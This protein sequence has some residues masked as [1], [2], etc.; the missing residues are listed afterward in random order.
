MSRCGEHF[1]PWWSS[2]LPRADVDVL[3]AAIR[4]SGLVASFIL[5]CALAL[6]VLADDRL[7]ATTITRGQF[8]D[9]GATTPPPDAAPWEPVTLPDAW[10]TTRPNFQL[11]GWYRLT[12]NV[13]GLPEKE[14]VGLYIHTSRTNTEIY[15]NG[16]YVGASGVIVGPSPDRIA[17]SQLHVLPIPKLR[18]GENVLHLRVYRPGSGGGISDIEVGEYPPLYY[19][20]LTR[21]LYNYASYALVGVTIATIGLFV[22]LRWVK[23]RPQFESFYF[24][25]GALAWGLHSLFRLLPGQRFPLHF[26]AIWHFSNLVSVGLLVIFCLRAAKRRWRAFELVVW[27]CMLALLPVFY[28]TAFI[29]SG[30]LGVLPQTTEFAHHVFNVFI[31]VALA[32][33]ALRVREDRGIESWLLLLGALSFSGPRLISWVNINE[34]ASLDALALMPAAIMAFVLI[35]GWILVDRFVRAANDNE[36]LNTQLERRVAEKAQEL[37]AQ[38]T[39]T[40]RAREDAEKANLAKSRFLA[41]AS[42]DLRQPLHA[43]GLFAAALNDREEDPERRKLVAHINQSIGALDSLFNGVLDVSKLDAGAV[44]PNVRNVPLQRVFDRI[45][46]EFAAEA[47]SQMLRLRLRPSGLVVRS[48]PVLLD[49]ILRNLVQNAIRYTRHGGVL[50]GARQRGAHA[51]VEV[52]DTGIGI[53]AQEQSRIFEE[54]YQVGNP[55]RD[56]GKGLGL[57]LAIVERLSTLLG[58][59]LA[60]QSRP[61]RGS[62]FRLTLEIGNAA[63]GIDAGEPESEA[64]G[65]T[66]AVSDRCVAIID[67]EPSV[68]SGMAALL[69][70]WRCETVIAA[71]EAEAV[72]ALLAAGK[73]PAA[74]VVDYR[75]RDNVNGIAVI[76]SL[77]ARFGR[78][79]PAVIISGESSTEELA[80]IKASGLPMLHKPVRPAKLRSVIFFLLGE[81]KAAA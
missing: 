60:V 7:T 24:G 18:V 20:W 76:R 47:E 64:T 19:K 74:L 49:R 36:R 29:G 46:A 55:E 2:L 56:R 59:P 26:T 8:L 30:Y 1:F 16:E 57:G 42:H 37:Q 61:T 23:R 13:D 33:V 52:W 5:A 3:R 21:L 62:V 72:S 63:A 31:V 27:I 54:F 45:A 67:D 77:R 14:G 41:A 50:V 39:A 58:H 69:G 15:V 25:A 75:L 80:H 79:I 73:T 17:F 48:D 9:T 38:L 11:N 35:A 81:S 6:P 22:L 28:A 10:P 68:R 71:D 66:E 12:F 34:Q 51:Q 40:E 70:S 78:D 43:L 4:W 32:A 53:P 44:S 65:D